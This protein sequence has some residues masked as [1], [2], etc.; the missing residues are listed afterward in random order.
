MRSARGFTLIEVLVVMAIIGTL[1]ALVSF[2]APTRSAANVET[3]ALRFYERLRYANDL[4]TVQRRVLALALKGSDS[5]RDPLSPSNA[6]ST[7]G[8]TSDAY[9]YLAWQGT[10]GW[11]LFD[12]RGLGEKVLSD[13]VEVTFKSFDDD[14]LDRYELEDALNQWHDGD[15]DF[16]LPELMLLGDGRI[17]RFSARFAL[18]GSDTFTM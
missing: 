12:Q 17:P 6:S 9:R 1:A 7:N 2:V 15:K 8:I 5:F 13:D 10:E 3:E 14:L 4:A 18:K 11:V 16:R